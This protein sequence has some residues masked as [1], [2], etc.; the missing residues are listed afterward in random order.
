MTIIFFIVRHESKNNNNNE[1]FG[2]KWS[3]LGLVIGTLGLFEFSAEL[4]RFKSWRKA[5]EVSFLLDIINMWILVPIW[6]YVLGNQLKAEKETF[7]NWRLPEEEDHATHQLNL[8]VA[9]VS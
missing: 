9:S 2:K 7:E 6:L 1:A 8:E 4:M 3:I 5:S